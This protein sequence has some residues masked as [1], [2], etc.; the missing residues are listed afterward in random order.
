MEYTRAFVEIR[1]NIRQSASRTIDS[2]EAS[3]LVA[4][5]L[6]KPTQADGVGKTIVADG[7]TSQE[8]PKSEKLTKELPL[9]KPKVDENASTAQKLMFD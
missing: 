4:T 5:S 7:A 3:A 1:R 2:V 9:D 8:A 6:D